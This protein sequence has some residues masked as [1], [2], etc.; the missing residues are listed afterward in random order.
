[1]IYHN[2]KKNLKVHTFI[3]NCLVRQHRHLP[4]SIM[5]RSLEREVRQLFLW[6]C[7]RLAMKVENCT[8]SLNINVQTLIEF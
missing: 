1:M 8:S 5:F 7:Q 3:A 2:R 4:F 6:V